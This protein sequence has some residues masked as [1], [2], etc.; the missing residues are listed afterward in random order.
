MIPV[1]V[2]DGRGLLQKIARI[3]GPARNLLAAAPASRQPVFAH[4]SPQLIVAQAERL[5]GATLALPM[6]CQ[7]FPQ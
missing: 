3:A 7:R 1:E 4:Q 2:G 5:R 6:L